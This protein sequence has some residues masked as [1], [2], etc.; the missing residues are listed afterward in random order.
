VYTPQNGHDLSNEQIQFQLHFLD[1]PPYDS[2]E[3]EL[4]WAVGSMDGIA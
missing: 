2:L 4:A 3:E 1:N